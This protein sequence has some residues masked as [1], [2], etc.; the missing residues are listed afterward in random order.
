M[1]IDR[2]NPDLRVK[3]LEQHADNTVT[4]EGPDGDKKTGPAHE[5]FARFREATPE[6]IAEASVALQGDDEK[7]PS[8]K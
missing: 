5:F 6:E 3:L 2:K 4:I 7:E 1:F 8:T